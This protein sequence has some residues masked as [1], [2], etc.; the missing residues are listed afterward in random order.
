MP[1]VTGVDSLALHSAALQRAKSAQSTGVRVLIGDS[2]PSPRSTRSIR[3][4][5]VP[6][7]TLSG[8]GFQQR[9]S[10]GMELLAL[11]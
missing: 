8:A 6:R 7:P 10:R 2:S 9:G 3:T 5:S 11:G 1:R 4:A